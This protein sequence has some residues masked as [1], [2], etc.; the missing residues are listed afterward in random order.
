MR[1]A[2]EYLATGES[3]V[4]NRLGH[5]VTSEL[6]FA[7]VPDDPGIP[8]YFRNKQA[9]IIKELS[10]RTWKPNLEGDRVRATIHPM[11]FKTAASFARRIWTLYNQ[12]EEYE[13]SGFIPQDD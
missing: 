7:N 11:R 4:K 6:L 8:Q 5:A 12:L 10:S 13:H 3:E 9:G 2:T 1:A